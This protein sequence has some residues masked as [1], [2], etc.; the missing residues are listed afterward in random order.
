M[1]QCNPIMHPPTIFLHTQQLFHGNI[2]L[3]WRLSLFMIHFPNTF[4]CSIFGIDLNKINLQKKSFTQYFKNIPWINK[5][6]PKTIP[7]SITAHRILKN[8]NFKNLNSVTLWLITLQCKEQI[9]WKFYEN[10]Y[11]LCSL[12]IPLRLTIFHYCETTFWLWL[13]LP[14]WLWLIRIAGVDEQWRIDEQ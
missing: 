13:W 14:L 1:T 2:F 10:M 7:S 4:C 11:N 12:N 9:F 8:W 5:M 3:Q 6:V